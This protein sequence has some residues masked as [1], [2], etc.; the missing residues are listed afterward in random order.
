MIGC[1]CLAQSNIHFLD[2]SEGLSQGTVTSIVEDNFGYLW[3]GTLN[4]LNR[5]NGTEMRNFYHDEHDSVSIPK[6]NIK[7]LCIDDQNNL[8]IGTYGK[9]LQR[10]D[11]N[12]GKVK[13]FIDDPAFPKIETIK[14]Y[15]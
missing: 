5:Y 4:G 2:K 3:I 11:L 8:W 9:G 13:N 10:R 14:I 12:T 15:T 7:A 6:N 1:S